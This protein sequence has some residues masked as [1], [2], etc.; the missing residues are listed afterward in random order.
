MKFEMMF[1]AI[2][3]ELVT[4]LGPMAATAREEFGFDVWW[5]PE[6]GLFSGRDV[7]DQYTTGPEPAMKK[8]RTKR[9]PQHKDALPPAGCY[10]GYQ[11]CT[12]TADVRKGDGWMCVNCYEKWNKNWD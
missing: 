8:K 10:A 1:D 11:G 6:S 9:H 7:A 12:K 2:N 5:N 4:D 3:G